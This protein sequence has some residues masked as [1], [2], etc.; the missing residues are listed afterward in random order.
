MDRGRPDDPGAPDSWPDPAAG[1]WRPGGADSDDAAPTEVWPRHTADNWPRQDEATTRVDGP[2]GHHGGPGDPARPPEP[3]HPPLRRLTP[4]RLKPI[5]QE[6]RNGFWGLATGTVLFVMVAAGSAE[7]VSTAVRFAEH[8]VFWALVGVAA[9]VSVH[10]E[11]RYGWEPKPRW[12][13]AF[14]AV[15]GTLTAEVLALT[16]GSA[17]VIVGSLITLALLLFLVLMFG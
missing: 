2:S 9:L 12:P 16:A 6:R 4:A 13:W 10:R 15:A 3:A 7:Y 8:V 1:L 14:A 17:V 11:H 5:V